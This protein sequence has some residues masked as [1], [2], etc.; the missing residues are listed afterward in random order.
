MPASD[1]G[2]FEDRY[3]IIPRVL[4]FI[5]RGR[6]VLLIKGA[7]TKRLWANTYNGIGGHV[8]KGE[9]VLSAAYRELFEESGISEVNLNLSGII[10]IDTGESTGI[11]LFVFRGDIDEGLAVELKPSDEGILEWVHQ[12]DM[13]SIPL[14]ED[15]PVLL[16]KILAHKIG[17][18]PIYGLY[19]YSKS[20][21]L[22]IRFVNSRG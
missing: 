21:D 6:E 12:F 10:N 2:D 19:S 4:I 5:T 9:D 22:Q 18:P 15:L 20:G 11:N 17:K 3:K 13:V 14:V 16:P 7:S 1:Q 8:E